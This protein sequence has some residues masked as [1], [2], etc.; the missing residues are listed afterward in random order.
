MAWH[1]ND[2]QG[3]DGARSVS[4]STRPQGQVRRFRTSSKDGANGESTPSYPPVQAICRALDVMRA[5]NMHGVASVNDIYEETGFPKPSIIRMLETF[6]AEGYV[7]RDRM[8]SGYR[9]TERV[10][11]LSSGYESV[12]QVIEYSR[13]LAISLTQETNWPSAIAVIDGNEMSI[14][15]WTGAIS[16]WS[17]E[18]LIGLRASLYDSALGRAYMAFC[19]EDE[20]EER[21]VAMRKDPNINLTAE[22]EAAFRELLQKVQVDGYAQREPNTWP[23]RR[24]SVATAIMH[25]DRVQATIALSYFTTAVPANRMIDEIYAPLREATRKVEEMFAFFDARRG[26]QSLHADQDVPEF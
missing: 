9:V 15:F 20:R 13:P 3:P 21:L 18:S 26:G 5:V 16:P 19:P 4:K 1:K 14:Q 17:S 7:V 25:E 12:S 23:Q 6:V 24:S 8:C 10:R 22:K 2:A 11:D